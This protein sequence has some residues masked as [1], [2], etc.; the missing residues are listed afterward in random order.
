MLIC[1][2]ANASDELNTKGAADVIFD[3][4]HFEESVKLAF[5]SFEEPTGF[6]GGQYT[7]LGN[8][9]EDHD[10]VNNDSQNPLD[11]I[12]FV[13]N[14]IG[15]NARFVAPSNCEDGISRDWNG[16]TSFTGDLHDGSS[17]FEARVFS[18]FTDGLQGYQI[19]D[20]D[21]TLILESEDIDLTGRVNLTFGLDYFLSDYD[22]FDEPVIDYS[23][24]E[25]DD[26]LRVYAVNLD[27]MEEYEAVNIKG[28]I[29]ADSID[30]V[31]PSIEF[32]WNSAVVN[33][34]S[35]IRVKIVIEASMNSTNERIYLDNIVIRGL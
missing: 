15:F 13:S 27:T 2:A 23:D 4:G 9:C 20:V 25:I 21:G 5:T 31:V 11:T 12:P 24:W 33:L 19:N 10:L 8:P 22:S 18:A 6:I 26:F 14:E 17:D 35:N 32:V 29:N 1:G 30:N 3:K 7:S 16:V 28:G 34:P